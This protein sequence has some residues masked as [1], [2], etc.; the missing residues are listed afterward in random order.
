MIMAKFTNNNGETK[1]F[2]LESENT[3]T[4]FRHIAKDYSGIVAK[5]CY[6]NRTW[7]RY[8]FQSLL[9]KLKNK[10]NLTPC[11]NIETG[12]GLKRIY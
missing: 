6:Q 2:V 9:Y 1:T 12:E 11:F 4:G 10:Y 5:C 8:D 7:E 3:R